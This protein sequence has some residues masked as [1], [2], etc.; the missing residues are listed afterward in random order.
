[1]G[2]ELTPHNT[3][4]YSWE[5]FKN[6]KFM[7]NNEELQWIDDLWKRQSYLFIGLVYWE[8]TIPTHVGLG[9]KC[10]LAAPQL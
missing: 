3:F 9:E 7:V 5:Y 8:K 10:T 1:M 2:S 6:I 4:S